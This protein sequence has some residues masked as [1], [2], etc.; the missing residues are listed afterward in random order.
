MY[1]KNYLF[2]LLRWC[3]YG[4]GVL[5]PYQTEVACKYKLRVIEQKRPDDNKIRYSSF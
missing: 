4:M 3:F 2:A 5:S 1:L